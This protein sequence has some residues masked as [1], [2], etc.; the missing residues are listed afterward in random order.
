MALLYWRGFSP[1]K[2]RELRRQWP[3]TWLTVTLIS[4]PA[5][6]G[7]V[8]I[9]INAHPSRINSRR[10]FV[11]IEHDQVRY[12]GIIDLEDGELCQRL[13][14]LLQRNYG[15]KIQEIGDMEIAIVTHSETSLARP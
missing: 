7:Q 4:P 5:P 1:V 9:L 11:W 3:P 14:E 6:A 2:L 10:I 12:L 8:G 15:K 13:I